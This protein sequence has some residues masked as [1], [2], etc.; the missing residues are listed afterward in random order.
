MPCSYLLHPPPADVDECA[1]AI[2]GCEQECTNEVGSHSCGCFTGYRFD[3]ENEAV[4]CV[5]T[6]V[7]HGGCVWAQGL[8]VADESAG[9]NPSHLCYYRNVASP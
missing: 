7:L 2:D 1:E 4:Q 6:C 3:T 9:T 5:G 8:C